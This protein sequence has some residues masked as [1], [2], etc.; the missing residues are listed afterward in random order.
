ATALASETPAASRP[1]ASKPDATFFMDEFP[2]RFDCERTSN[3]RASAK[4][5]P[6][7]GV[8]TRYLLPACTFATASLHPSLTSAMCDCKQ[9]VAALPDLES[10]QNCFTS[11]LQALPTAAARTIATWQS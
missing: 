8:S 1:S 3:A 11:A 9:A 10:A 4:T 7:G 5:A 6:R 2:L